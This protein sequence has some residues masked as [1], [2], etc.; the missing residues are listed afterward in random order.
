MIQT[1]HVLPLAGT[2]A[3]LLA[4]PVAI[5]AQGADPSPASGSFTPAGSLAEPR[6][7]PTATALGDGRILVVGGSVM[8]A[9]D[10][11]SVVTDAETWDPR[12]RSFIEMGSLAEARAGHTSRLLLDGRV[13]I[14]GGA[15]GIDGDILASAE[16]WAP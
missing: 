9:D 16:L 14:V 3:L 10:S 4:A 13:L 1:R 6:E 2:L 12:T 5:P 7:G 15:G 11:W 8:A